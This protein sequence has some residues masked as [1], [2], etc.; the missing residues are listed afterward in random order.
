[1]RQSSN[2]FNQPCT[3]INRLHRVP[4]KTFI[5]SL[6]VLFAFSACKK[7]KTTWGSDWVAPMVSDTLSLKELENDSTLVINSFANYEVN[8]TRTIVDLGLKDIIQIPDTSIVQVYT[9]SSGSINIPPGYTIVNQIEEHNLN[10]QGVQLKRIRVS[11][12]LIKVTVYN[13]LP[14]VANFVVQLPGVEKDGVLFSQGYTAPAAIGNNP[15]IVTANLDI[16][17]YWIDLTGEFGDSYNKLQSKL[18]VTSSPTGPSVTLSSQD[19][20]KVEARFEE[21]KMNYA[22]GYFGN[23]IVSDTVSTTIDLMN[24]IESGM[25]DLPATDLR[26]EIENGMKVSAKATL[27][28]VSN[29]NN[30]NNVVVLSSPQIGNPIYMDAATGSWSTLTPKYENLEF[31][32]SNSNLES[33][34]ENLGKTHTIG[35]KLELNPWGNVSGGWDEIFPHSRLKVKLHAE[36]PMTLGLDDLTL[37][38]TFN[39]DLTQDKESSHVES[40]HIVLNATNAFPFKG[41]VVLFLM[42]ENGQV[43]H[44]VSGS[45][46]LQS[47]LYGSVDSADGLRKMKSEV[48]FI[49]SE[50]AISDLDIIRKV[51]VRVKLDTP[52]PVS[53]SNQQVSIPAGA[54]LAVKLKAM[55]RLKVA[56]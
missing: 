42:T 11:D 30:S 1:M 32:A 53:G 51:C 15:G 8:L 46:A 24:T 29:T 21:I 19:V 38:D 31:T 7:E 22:R 37:R 28:T 23:K 34:L 12:G 10:V 26:F 55:F 2:V 41:Q 40:G 43:L 48:H 50:N 17:G 6:L 16:S 5:F 27:T 9:L 49:L 35:Y 56:L 54:F 52:D 47:S 45:S 3:F 44:T 36:L 39:I 18:I 4:I 13:P 33:Y 14:T 25:V 20:I